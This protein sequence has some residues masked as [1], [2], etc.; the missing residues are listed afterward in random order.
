MRSKLE[1]LNQSFRK[2]LGKVLI[3]VGP[4]P[5]VVVADFLLDPSRRRGRVWLQT[6]QP[7][8]NELQKKRPEIQ[9]RLREHL[10]TRY[11]PK[12]T[13]FLDDGYLDNLDRL[14]ASLKDNEN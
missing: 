5:A 4:A 14:L 13:L 8:L 9:R 3:E 11:T 7:V 10:K 2:A 1:I 12:L 6:S